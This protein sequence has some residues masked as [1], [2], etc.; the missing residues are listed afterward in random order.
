MGDA[1]F[2]ASEAERGTD[3]RALVA[4]L[5]AI[6]HRGPNDQHV[7]SA[8]RASVGVRRLSIIDLGGGRQPLAG[9]DGRVWAGNNGELYNFAKVRDAL[10]ARGHAFRTR[11]DTEILPHL[12]E[13]HGPDF[14]Q[15]IEGMFACFVVDERAERIVLARDRFG[16]K[17]LY[18]THDGERL[19]FASE[20]RALLADPRV[21]ARV[22]RPR[23]LDYL[24]LGYVPGADTVLEGVHRLPAGHR[25]VADRD[26]IAIEPYDPPGRGAVT[27]PVDPRERL[28]ALE[29]RLRASVER[30]LVSDVPLGI[31]LSG[32]IDSSLI[33]ALLPEPIRRASRSFCIGFAGGGWHDERAAART[34]AQHLGTIHVEKEIQLDARAWTVRAGTALD[35]PLADP[36]AVPALAIASAAAEDVTVLLS[37]T[38]GDEL[39]G[40]YRRHRIGSLLRALGALPRPVAARVGEALAGR[41]GSRTSRFAE[42]LVFAGKTLVARGQPTLLGAYLSTQSQAPD[43]LWGRLALTDAVDG[44]S[45]AAPLATL[46]ARLAGE[47]ADAEASPADL[48]LGYDRRYYLPD[49]LLLKEDRMTMA[50]SV[51]GRVPFLDELV[52][53]YADALPLDAKLRGE[54]K[55]ILR[56]LLRRHLPPAITERPKHGFS[57]PVSEWLRGPLA[58][59]V[60]ERLGNGGASGAWNAGVARASHRGPHHRCARSRRRAVD[61]AAV[62]AVVGRAVGPGRPAARNPMRP[63]RV[64]HV[65]TRMVV[66]GAQENTLLSCALI[67]RER[68]PSEIVSGV[69]TGSEGSLHEDAAARGVAVRLEPALVREVHPVKDPL[70]LAR[71]VGL[72]RSLRPDVVHTHT[73]K[74]GILGRVAARMARVP[75]VIHTAHGWGFHPLQ[76][77]PVR[78]AYEEAER[79]CARWSDAI[80]VVA[81]ENRER[82]LKLAI[83]RPAQYVTLRSGIELEAYRHDAVAGA[84]VRARLA[85]PA[86]GF[87]F[88]TVGRLSD[89][90]APLDAL[91][92]FARV[93]ADHPDTWFVYVGD[94]PLR[95]D[96]EREAARLGLATRVRWT[97]LRRDVAAHLSAFDA[98]VLS[99]RYEGLPR[100]VPQA[101]AVGLPVAATAVDGTPEAVDE[102]VSGFLVPP[103]DV[104]A[105]ARAMAALAADREGARRM[106][107]A[108]RARADEFSARRMVDG[109]ADL[110]ATLARAKG[111]T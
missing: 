67:D 20:L 26:R 9:E 103:G 106:G 10:A 29:Q 21:P 98:F 19:R 59:L 40:G 12:F 92:A 69:E 66:G 33:T 30:Q 5:G 63:L 96:T 86:D 32:G 55:W 44:A 7:H 56:Q 50:V 35:E 73:S 14:V 79:F 4:M 43:A 105:L 72:Y 104:P 77:P 1:A 36:A 11:T 60:H 65:I 24:A 48:A 47:F 78:R 62:G 54:G 25:L 17:P 28:D 107:A 109:L 81:D 39:F 34:V 100:V 91:H 27:V 46:T 87:V 93:A 18:W 52:A 41:A 3:E 6:A 51:E 94:G 90:K 61:G 95:A 45:P 88:G 53:P 64:L 108:G 83:G 76:S 80:V 57:V 102:G 111:V 84:D 22:A 23:F 70:A 97:G 49:D 8:G 85:L 37:G 15:H 101:M 71:L 58:P 99:S 110:Y 89:Q 38:G 13:D 2:A 75:V 68:F 16:I 42:A 82:A 31:L 74:A